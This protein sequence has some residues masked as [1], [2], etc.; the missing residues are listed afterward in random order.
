ML[1]LLH[2][3]VVHS[4]NVSNY[5]WVFVTNFRNLWYQ[6]GVSNTVDEDSLSECASCCQQGCKG[7]KTLLQQNPAL[8]NWECWLTRI[9]L[10][11]GCRMLLL[12]FVLH[13][14]CFDAVC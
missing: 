13:L 7:S 1:A 10:Y 2:S 4:T 8:L 14:Q 5:L 11:N 3:L 6:D 9:D 12:L